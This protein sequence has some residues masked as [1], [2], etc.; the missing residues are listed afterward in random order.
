MAITIGSFLSPLVSQAASSVASSPEIQQAT[1]EVQAEIATY[2][3]LAKVVGAGL[4]L[5]FVFYWLPRF[6]SPFELL[7]GGKD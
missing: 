5:V 3:L 2:S 7:H 1:N 4:A 6:R